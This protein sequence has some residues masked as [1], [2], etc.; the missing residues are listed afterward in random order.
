MRITRS[1]TR[2]TANRRRHRPDQA[3]YR[4]LR[5]G[6]RRS[7]RDRWMSWTIAVLTVV[8][9]VWVAMKILRA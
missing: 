8:V 5:I 6:R 7:V 3:T 2:K 1:R 4:T 9:C